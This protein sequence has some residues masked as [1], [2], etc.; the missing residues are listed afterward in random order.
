MKSIDNA[1]KNFK[2]PLNKLFLN[3]KIITKEITGEQELGIMKARRRTI[4][5]I[6]VPCS[7]S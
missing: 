4:A 2:S 5:L 3:M 7:T 1:K 6:Y